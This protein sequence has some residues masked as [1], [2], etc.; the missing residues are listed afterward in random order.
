MQEKCDNRS[1][2][3]L[4][5]MNMT[6]SRRTWP[7][8]QPLHCAVC[9]SNEG[10][11]GESERERCVT[12][13]RNGGASQGCIALCSVTIY[14]HRKGRGLGWER[15]AVV[16]LSDR[17]LTTWIH[18]SPPSRITQVPPADSYFRISKSNS[19]LARGCIGWWRTRY[20]QFRDNDPR[21]GRSVSRRNWPEE[22]WRV[23]LLHFPPRRDSFC[24]HGMSAFFFIVT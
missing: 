8:S 5:A 24:R 14:T 6:T 1:T 11:K 22:G 19:A 12:A 13:K 3:Q 7:V 10:K 18:R 4:H 15:R 20:A 23:Q 17:C 21:D 2:Q 9:L 16:K